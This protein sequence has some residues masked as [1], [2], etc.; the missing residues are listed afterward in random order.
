[1]RRTLYSESLVFLSFQPSPQQNAAREQASPALGDTLSRSERDGKSRGRI[2]NPSGAADLPLR[3][4]G[5]DT[6][7]PQLVDEVCHSRFLTCWFA[8]EWLCRALA[9]PGLNPDAA[10]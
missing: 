3:E 5:C 8:G 9:S 4:D 10:C 2:G 6:L 7:R 1:M